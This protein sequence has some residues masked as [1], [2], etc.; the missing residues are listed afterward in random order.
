MNAWQASTTRRTWTRRSALSLGATGLAAAGL[1]ALGCTPRTEVQR[2]SGAPETVR[3]C[4]SSHALGSGTACG[5]GFSLANDVATEGGTMLTFTCPAMRDA[6]ET[7]GLY[8][9]YASTLVD[10]DTYAPVTCTAM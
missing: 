10:E 7:G 1:A 6:T 8:S 3:L 9:V 4:E 2:T 5:H